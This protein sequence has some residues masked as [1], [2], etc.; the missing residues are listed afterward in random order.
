MT[1][2]ETGY[3]HFQK[4]QLFQKWANAN[5][6]EAKALDLYVNQLK[7]GIKG[8]PPTMASEFGKALTDWA[9]MATP[10]EIKPGMYGVGMYGDGN[11]G[12]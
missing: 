6:N 1:L 5:K 2:L 10:I 12:G 9:S 8:T 4:A 3:A 7:V 11:Y